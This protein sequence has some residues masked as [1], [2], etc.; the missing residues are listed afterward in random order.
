MLQTWS[1]REDEL[2]REVGIQTF[3]NME[4]ER[5]KP[6]EFTVGFT[7]RSVDRTHSD[8]LRPGE[9]N[10]SV[11]IVIAQRTEKEAARVR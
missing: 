3:D 10:R 4:K 11:R 9:R 2:F 1:G 7:Q 8:V 5:N 6:R